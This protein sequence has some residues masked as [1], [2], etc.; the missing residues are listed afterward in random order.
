M[1]NFDYLCKNPDFSTF[2]ETAV[3]AEKL[4]GTDLQSCAI[5]CRRSLE[6]AVR[7]LYSVDKSLKE[8]WQDNLGTL[9][10]TE[11]FRK[12]IGE[13][14]FKRINYIR[15]L[16]NSTAHSSAKTSPEQA[17]LALK[18]LFIFLDY[19]AYCYS[20][21]YTEHKFDSSLLGKEKQETLANESEITLKQLIAQNALLVEELTKRR[22]TREPSYVP[23]PLGISE[24][25]T[26]KI[27]IDT[28]LEEAGWTLGKDRLDEYELKGMLNKS[29]VGFADY[30]LFGDDGRPLAVIEAKKT[31]KDVSVGR[32]QAKLYADL[33]EKKFG[34]RPIIFLSNGFETRIWNDTKY[35]E[36]K[37]SCIYSKR[38][39]E[40]EFN[41]LS[42]RSS[43]ADI[44]INENISNRYYQKEAIKSVCSAF[45]KENRR[46]ALLVMATGSGKTRTVISIVD[47]LLKH[48]W[49]KNILFL[50]DR[51]G[52]VTQAKRAF[53]NLLPDLSLTNLCEDKNNQNARAVFSTYQ[54]MMNAIDSAKDED[55]KKLFTSGHFD[56]IIVDEAHRSIYNKYKDIF[57]YFDSHIIGLTATPKDDIDK[58]TYEIFELENGVPTY[59]YELA[60]AVTDGYLTDLVS[61]ET[62]LKFIQEGIAYDDLTE[63]EKEEYE[64]YFTDEDGNLP[65]SINPSALNE[66]IFNTDTIKKVLATVMENGQRV[67][68]GSKIGKTIIFAKNHLHAEKIY[69]VFGKEYPSYSNYCRVIDNY[70]NYSQTLIDEFSEASKMPQIAISVDMLDTG[71]DIPEI[72]NLVFF[73]RVM[74]RAKFWQMIGRGT[75]LCPNLIDGKDKELFY[76]FDFCGNFEFFR[77]TG[78]GK[79]AVAQKSVQERIFNLKCEMIY[80]LQG[81][82][83]QTDEL[84]RFRNGLIEDVVKKVKE[85]NRENFAVK[86]HLMYVDLYSD[87]NAFTALTYENTLQIAENLAPL[88]LPEDD[89]ASAVYFDSLVYGLELALIVNRKY[90]KARKDLIRKVQSIASISTIPEINEKAP[91]IRKILYTDYVKNAG[92]SDFERIR[93]E[94]RDLMKYIPLGERNIYETNF[95][96]D[97]IESKWMASDIGEDYLKNYKAKAEHYLKE[98][99]NEP[100]IAKL[101]TNIPLSESDIKSLE[102]ILWKEVGTKKDYAE[103]AGDKPLGVF[104][105]EIIGLEMSAA[106][107]AFSKYLTEEN[108]NPNQIYFVNRIVEYIVKNG[109]MKDMSVLTSSPFTDRGTVSDIFDIGTWSGIRSVIE[110][111][112]RNAMTV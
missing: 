56:L 72:L 45:D 91:L 86:Q 110:Q 84:T 54:T 60:Q 82:D 58:N 42:R 57:T 77:V 70:T 98:H 28:D 13:D 83:Y 90:P 75:R 73:K 61:V 12:L 92:I 14:L 3:S 38:D 96:D 29:G 39:L 59:G 1:T 18:N 5:N 106:K 24:Y 4:Y 95:T 9:I 23:K 111:I 55:G 64:K 53:S 88:I 97:L 25:E 44:E 47:L 6:F 37:V 80:K 40:K 112:N 31:C 102:G 94:L 81:L 87:K 33:L 35:P 48:S 78:K 16:G 8:P 51:N 100:V 62:K 85:L 20:K 68:Y 15:I 10:H 89:D 66:W 49:I 36:R 109:V 32:Q 27:Y 2:A 99:E 19:I 26:R 50:A 41:K 65:E 104:V 67:E 76:I 30:V 46:K 101:K 69:K 63:E 71:I 7:W 34:R 105:R 22:Q 107:E 43:L 93:T 103:E 52:L 21:D 108:L 79:E 17:E 74:S 11:E